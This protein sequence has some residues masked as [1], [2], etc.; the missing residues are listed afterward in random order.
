VNKVAPRP[1]HE[2][3]ISRQPLG[4]RANPTPDCEMALSNVSVSPKTSGLCEASHYTACLHGGRVCGSTR[5][6]KGGTS[7]E[8]GRAQG[9]GR[10]FCGGWVGTT[11]GSDKRRWAFGQTDD[12]WMHYVGGDEDSYGVS[13]SLQVKP[14]RVHRE[15]INSAAVSSYSATVY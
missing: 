2:D 6:L 13:H 4:V 14:M 8:L 12:G 11:D 7:P 9:R 15:I 5:T 10:S 3:E 1:D